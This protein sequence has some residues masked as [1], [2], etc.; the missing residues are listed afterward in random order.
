MIVQAIEAEEFQAAAMRLREFLITLV[1]S[2]RRRVE[3]VDGADRP[4]DAD[5]PGWSELLIN[6]FCPGEP[7]KVLRQY[8]KSTADRT[9]Q[10]VN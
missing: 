5:V 3:L 7:N 2:V 4:R 8:L 6:H 1:G 10:L 9:W